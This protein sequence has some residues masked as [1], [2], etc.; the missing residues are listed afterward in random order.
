MPWQHVS[1]VPSVAPVTRTYR[2]GMEIFGEG[3]TVADAYR[4]VS[5]AVR[6]CKYLGDGRRQVLGF[7]LVDE[8]FG[9][10]LGAERSASAEAMMT[11]TV[12]VTSVQSATSSG[13]FVDFFALATEHLH[14]AH[15][16][17]IDL[18]RKLAHERIASFFLD[19]ARRFQSTSL[20]MPM[21]RGDIADYLGL[22]AETVSRELTV[23]R[24]R[25]IPGEV[26][27]N[28][29]SPRAFKGELPRGPGKRSAGDCLTELRTAIA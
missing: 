2:A 19:L 25:P 29:A 24:V 23:W 21:P 7:H 28:A 14:Q 4:V 12:A 13:E 16:L 3:D 1:N 15:N 6:S 27:A 18:G 17:T 26:P 11:T 22:T 5:G 9:F 10:E 8:I 20:E